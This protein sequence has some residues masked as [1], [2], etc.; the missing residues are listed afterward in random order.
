MIISR[1]CSPLLTAL[2]LSILGKPLDRVFEYKYLG[3]W[4]TETLSWSKHIESITKR[5]MKLVGMV[6]RKF[7]SQS[8][9]ESLKRLYISLIRPHLKYAAPVWDPIAKL[10]SPLQRG[11]RSFP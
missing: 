4:I 3:V 6:Y 9:F 5:A 10:K 1:K 8:S 2:N 7:Y 11:Y